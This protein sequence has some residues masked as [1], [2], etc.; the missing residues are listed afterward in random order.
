[1]TMRVLI[2]PVDI[3]G[4]IGLFSKAQKECGVDAISAAYHSNKLIYDI[5]LNLELDKKGLLKYP[6]AVKFL[7][8]SFNKYDVYHFQFGKSLL[9][10]NLDLP[11]LKILNKKIIFHFWGCDIR[12][13]IIAYRFKYNA[14]V[15]CMHS[16]SCT[17][18]KYAR[19]KRYSDCL[20]VASPDLLE[21]LPGSKYVPVAIDLNKW[22][23]SASPGNKARNLKILHAPTNRDIKG[24]KYLEYA[25]DRL[26]TKG[27][28]IELVLIENIP[29]GKVLQYYLD[30]D[31][32]VDQLL[33][34]W[35][36]LFAVEAM[37]LGKPVISYIR[38]DLKK[39]HENLPVISANPDDI[40]DVLEK[41][42][43]NSD[44]REEKGRAGL[45]YVKKVHDYRIIGKRLIEIYNSEK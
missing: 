22:K 25:V 6:S 17:I 34:G 43:I 13:K 18:K 40:Q 9:P 10:L 15:G 41:L 45:E 14:C 31:I 33:L 42:I 26:K 36:G 21:L 3:A 8:E 23:P 32:V 30:S 24:T 28:P 19:I 7:L 11:V 44:I 35:Y 39:Y 20:I 16:D 29:H 38:E 37:A 2:A 5:D 27:Y 12:N 1:M 4:Q